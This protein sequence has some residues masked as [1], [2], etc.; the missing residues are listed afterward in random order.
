MIFWRPKRFSRTSEPSFEEIAKRLSEDSKI[1]YPRGL[2]LRVLDPRI[3]TDKGRSA[4][5]NGELDLDRVE[6]AK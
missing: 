5:R 3:L 6:A 1:E 4:T 2:R